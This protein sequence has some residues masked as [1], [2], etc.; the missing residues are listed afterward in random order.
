VS[1]RNIRKTGVH[2]G[3]FL[4]FLVLLAGTAAQA[5]DIGRYGP[6]QEPTAPYPKGFAGIAPFCKVVPQPQFNL[7]NDVTWYRP[8]WVCRSRG[9]Y[10]DTFWPNPWPY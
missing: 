2:A 1:S 8:I 10:T 9:V 7:Y 6:A 3:V 5:A 4:V